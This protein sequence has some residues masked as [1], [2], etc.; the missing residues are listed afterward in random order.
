M[1]NGSYGDTTRGLRRA[2]TR[3]LGPVEDRANWDELQALFHEVGLFPSKAQV[4]EMVQCARECGSRRRKKCYRLSSNSSASGVT[5]AE[6]DGC[7]RSSSSSNH[8]DGRRAAPAVDDEAENNL[9]FGE[10]AFFAAELIKYYGQHQVRD[11]GWRQQHQQQQQ[12]QQHQTDSVFVAAGDLVQPAPAPSSSSQLRT[13]KSSTSAYDVFL[14]GS[15]GPTTWR[16]DAA[17]PFLKSQGI[18]YYNPQ[19]SNWVP[20]M[21]ELEHQAKQTSQVLFF[22]LDEKTR[23]V[24]SMVEVSYLS[25]AGRRLIVVLSSYPTS[26]PHSICGEEISVTE[27]TDLNGAMTTV[28]DLVE[29]GGT[30]VFASMT[31]ALG[32]T[33]KVLREG[34]AVEELSLEDGAVPIRLAHVQLG[35]KLVRAREAFD[36]L[37]TAR[38]GKITLGDIRMAFRIHANGALSPGDLREILSAHDVDVAA[39]VA[40]DKGRSSGSINGLPLDRVLIDFDHFCCILAEF[41]N[42]TKSVSGR[43]ASG[44]SSERTATRY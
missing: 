27:C 31:T 37:D 5:S 16:A 43:G 42:R 30:P 34:V 39:A 35:D 22:V 7:N 11:K 12:D 41:K 18:T 29:R 33:R 6:N 21:I 26:A 44:G 25:G 10:F 8:S 19:Q 4:F 13:Q 17:I 28:H 24:V 38:A 36:T 3:R 40:T 20:E 23:N 1:S 9:T 14:G 32:C 15:C 2:W